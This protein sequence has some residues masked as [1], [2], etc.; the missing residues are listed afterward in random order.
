MLPI[1]YVSGK[2]EKH[3]FASPEM[4]HTVSS[5]PGGSVTIAPQV[6]T[7]LITRPFH[8]AFGRVRT[9]HVPLSMAGQL[10]GGITGD[11]AVLVQ[12]PNGYG[13]TNCDLVVR[14]AMSLL[15]PNMAVPTI[16]VAAVRELVGMVVDEIRVYVQD[17]EV[18]RG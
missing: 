10:P 6:L 1:S 15:A 16:V 5:Q 3:L 7:T 12:V 4:I 8:A 2:N 17:V 14:P 11:Q 18:D 13:H 9:D